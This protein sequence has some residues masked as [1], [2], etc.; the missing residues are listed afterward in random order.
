MDEQ[1]NL[2]KALAFAIRDLYGPVHLFHTVGKNYPQFKNIEE[3]VN[4]AFQH[5]EQHKGNTLGEAVYSFI[6]DKIDDSLTPK[7]LS[8]VALR[9]DHHFHRF[10]AMSKGI[11][12]SDLDITEI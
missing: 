8:K 2:A 5:L 3:I 9:I 4:L 1:M 10:E 12:Q 7:M 6:K 11:D